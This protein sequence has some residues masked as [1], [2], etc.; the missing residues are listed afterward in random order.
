[1]SANLIWATPEGDKLI[2]YMARVSNP[3]ATPEDSAEKLIEF[4][5]RNKHWSPFDMVNLCVEI[6]TTRDI[7]RQVLRHWSIHPQ[8]FSQRYAVVDLSEMQPR[9]M[10][11][12]GTTNRQGSL[13][14]RHAAFEREALAHA[15]RGAVLYNDMVNN[16][17]SAE[18]ARSILSEGYTPTRL[19][20]NGTIRSW[21]HYFEQR[22]DWHAQKEHRDLANEIRK[23]FI[24]H[25]PTVAMAIDL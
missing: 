10:R 9:E 25:Y 8:E 15:E 20:L 22:C 6:N 4:L 24:E 21:I 16:G 14:A 13:N 2:G 7:G 23:I 11:L 17:I 19:Y 12:K 5:I 1:M 18:S 3:N